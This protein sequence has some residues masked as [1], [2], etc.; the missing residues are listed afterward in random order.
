L[1]Q[2]IA[3]PNGCASVSV[4]FVSLAYSLCAEKLETGGCEKEAMDANSQSTEC[5]DG[6][7]SQ[8]DA[9]RV[10]ADAGY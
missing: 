2:I 3:F 9:I 6:L 10:F 5:T 4:V 1:K 7:K 8:T